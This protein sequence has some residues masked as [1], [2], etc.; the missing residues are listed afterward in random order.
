MCTMEKG[1]IISCQITYFPIDSKKYLDEI[2]EVLDLIKDSG[3]D[4]NVD[5]LSTT[6]R[7]EADKIFNLIA[8]I[9]KEMSHKNCNYTM[10]IMVSNICGCGL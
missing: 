7:G 10:N 3:L 2:D 4:H 5:I 1:S 8:N 6:I 9:H